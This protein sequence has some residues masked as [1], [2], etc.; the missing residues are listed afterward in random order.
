MAQHTW[1]TSHNWLLQDYADFLTSPV[2]DILNASFAEQKLPRSWKDADVTPLIKVN[3]V[4]TIAKH[5][6]RISLTPALSKLTEVFVVSKY[7][8]SAVLETIDY[9]QFGAIPNSSTLF[10]LISMIHTWAQAAGG[11]SSAVRVLCLDYREAF[12]LV[13]HGILAAQILGLRIPRKITIWVCDLL[14]DRHQRVHKTWPLAFHID[15]KL[16]PLFWI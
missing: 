5:I 16:S 7:I 6:R 3:P 8:G 1:H 4:T 13:D 12:D 9:N 10:A 15:D 2:C 14:M 11:I